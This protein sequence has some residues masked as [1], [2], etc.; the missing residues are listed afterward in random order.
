MSTSPLQRHGA[1]KKSSS[2]LGT[3]K[4]K[5]Q[6]SVYDAV[7]GRVNTSGFSVD[8]SS[9]SRHDHI[10]T[11]NTSPLAPEEALFKRRGAPPR[12]QENDF[13]WADQSLPSDQSL[14]DSELVKALHAYAAEFYSRATVDGGQTDFRSMDETA[15]LALS[16]LLEEASKHILGKSGH[17]VFLEGEEEEQVSGRSGPRIDSRKG[18]PTMR[19]TSLAAQRSGETRSRKKMKLAAAGSESSEV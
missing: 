14:P 18:R 2:N 17:L 16:I 3:I 13:Y 4:R 7:A 6:A 1:S 12:Y 8:N 9:A 19:S 5:R 10:S 15:L 11:T